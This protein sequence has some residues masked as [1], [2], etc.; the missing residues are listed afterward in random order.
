[1]YKII[2]ICS[3][4]NSSLHISEFIWAKIENNV[5]FKNL[6]SAQ[7][8]KVFYSSSLLKY[9]YLNGGSKKNLLADLF[10]H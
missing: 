9:K 1:M 6:V 10:K 5:F 8:K 3:N 2:R 4:K 7:I